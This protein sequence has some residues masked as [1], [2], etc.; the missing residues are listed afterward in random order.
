MAFPYIQYGQDVSAITLMG[1]GMFSLQI[2]NLS[3][4]RLSPKQALFIYDAIIDSVGYCEVVNCFN[5]DG[6]LEWE[7]IIEIPG[8]YCYL[9]TAKVDKD[10]NIYLLV[11]SKWAPLPL[12]SF[13]VKLDS[14]GNLLWRSPVIGRKIAKDIAY[15]IDW[16]DDKI[17][18]AGVFENFS[19]SDT[20]CVSYVSTLSTAGKNLS[21]KMNYSYPWSKLYWSSRLDTLNKVINLVSSNSHIK[22]S[23]SGLI[24]LTKFNYQSNE[25]EN[26]YFLDSI[27][28]I[29][30]QYRENLNDSIRETFYYSAPFKNKNGEL[31]FSGEAKGLTSSTSTYFTR[32]IDLNYKCLTLIDTNY[33]YPL[34]LVNSIGEDIFMFQFYENLKVKFVLADKNFQTIRL[35]NSF[36]DEKIFYDFLKEQKLEVFPLGL[37]HINVFYDVCIQMQSQVFFVCLP[38]YNATTQM[39][40]PLLLRLDSV[41]NIIPVNKQVSTKDYSIYPNPFTDKV[42]VETPNVGDYDLSFVNILGQKVIEFKQQLPAEVNLDTLPKGLYVLELRKDN[43]V[44]H[45]QRLVHD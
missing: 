5:E 19:M 2:Q 42:L 13:L 9:T 41:G 45:S 27:N 28:I 11:Q 3:L 24:G 30:P 40:Y 8:E 31:W 23:G 38:A 39:W 16:V 15:T 29:P 37:E 44:V 26:T 34:V 20:F 1:R 10:K 18:V 7:S 25:I 14:L 6:K 33:D 36:Y 17:F 21:L 35:L 22:K 43:K 32:L 4:T 12:T